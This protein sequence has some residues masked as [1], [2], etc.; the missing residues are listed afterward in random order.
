[1]L[2]IE[3]GV[4]SN[5]FKPIQD[6]PPSLGMTLQMIDVVITSDIKIYCEGLGQLLDRTHDLNVV[7]IADN[8]EAAMVSICAASPEILLLDMTMPGSCQLAKRISQDIPRTKI[9]ALAVSYDENNIV[10]CA[11]AGVTCYVPREAS[12]SELIDAIKEAAKGECYCPPKIAACLLK[13]MQDQAPLAKRRY[14]PVTGPDSFSTPGRPAGDRSR[15]TRRETQIASLLTEGF[16]NKQIAR[17]LC[18]EV[19]TVKNH[20]HNL[21]VK[22]KVK[23]RSQA[24]FQLQNSGSNKGSKSMGL[25][26]FLENPF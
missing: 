7:A 13:K 6:L 4:S 19:S 11:E 22:L 3:A 2:G 9:V 15:L 1:L 26:P 21:L 24:V 12:V 25:D 14:L 20:V 23:N 18:I 16:S 8:C 5:Q 10:Q 17:D